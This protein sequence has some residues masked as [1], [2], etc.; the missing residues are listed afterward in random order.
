MALARM[1][2][3]L[4]SEPSRVT[5][6]RRLPRLQP[7]GLR[8]GQVVR[9]QDHRAPA[10][11][12]PALGACEQVH[13]A[14]GDVRHI[15]GPG[16]HVGGVHGGKHRCAGLSRLLHGVFRTVAP[17]DELI[18]HAPE[19]L[20][21]QEQGMEVKDLRPLR[22]RPGPGRLRQLPEGPEGAAQGPV[23]PGGLLR[24]SFPG[25]QSTGRGSRR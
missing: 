5:M 17:G 9:T 1:A 18:H 11:H 16:L 7:E 6:A 8:G 14:A 23:Q 3:W 4:L 20:V 12:D 22:S 19:V 13:K 15:P 24:G 21:L 10:V 2:V 25:A